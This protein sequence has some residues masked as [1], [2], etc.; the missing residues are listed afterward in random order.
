MLA[1]LRHC[2]LQL[3]RRYLLL[4]RPGRAVAILQRAAR[5]APP[6]AAPRAPAMLGAP[7]TSPYLPISPTRWARTAA[8]SLRC[9]S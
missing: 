8:A 1:T 2:L 5:V 9:S 7:Y 4:R 3:A 6:A